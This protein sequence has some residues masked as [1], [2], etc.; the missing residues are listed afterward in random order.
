MDLGTYLVGAELIGQKWVSGVS[1]WDRAGV[2]L[3]QVTYEDEDGESV[4]KMVNAVY[5]R[6]YK[7]DFYYSEI[8]GETITSYV[9]WG[10]MLIDPP[11]KNKSPF[12]KKTSSG[13]DSDGDAGNGSR[14][15]TSKSRGR[16]RG[17]GKGKGG[18]SSGT[19]GVYESV[20]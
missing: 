16:G 2:K 12:A 18:G 17:R 15:G 3:Y 19:V 4:T 14:A 9:Y 1:D 20:Y 7:R 13:S 6:G 8:T 10:S 11:H 5:C